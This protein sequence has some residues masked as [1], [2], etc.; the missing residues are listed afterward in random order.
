MGNE[1]SIGA[2][3]VAGAA[4]LGIAVSKAVGGVISGSSAMLSEAAHSVLAAARV[5]FRDAATAAGIEWLR[6]DAE[7]MLRTRHP[8]TRAAATFARMITTAE[9]FG[10]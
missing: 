10:C 8:G 7:T 6:E 9:M 2:V 3:L 5:D 4:N 1:E